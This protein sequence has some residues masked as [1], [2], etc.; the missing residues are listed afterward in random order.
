MRRRR[1]LGGLL[2][3]LGWGFLLASVVCVIGTVLLYV[4]VL[5]LVGE[6]AGGVWLEW[7]Q[8]GV[9]VIAAVALGYALHA[10]IVGDFER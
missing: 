3:A 1:T 2:E 7:E 5:L 4:P 8:F 6:P 10:W 9:F